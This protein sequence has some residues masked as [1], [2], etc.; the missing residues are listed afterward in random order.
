[1]TGRA[2]SPRY[3]FL[4]SN[5]QLPRTHPSGNP[6]RLQQRSRV[7]MWSTRV[8]GGHRVEK[9]KTQVQRNPRAGMISWMLR[10]GY[11]ECCRA[12]LCSRELSPGDVSCVRAPVYVGQRHLLACLACWVYSK[13]VRQPRWLFAFIVTRTKLKR[14]FVLSKLGPS[15]AMLRSHFPRRCNTHRAGSGLPVLRS[16]GS[17]ARNETSDTRNMA[18]VAHIGTCR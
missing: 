7:D 14:P 17:A 15:R 8:M 4:D 11:S 16:F 12:A 6:T 5:Q 3:T 1:M 18:L 2:H 13:Y 9:G 10:V